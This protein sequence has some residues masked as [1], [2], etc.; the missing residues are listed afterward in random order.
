MWNAQTMKRS[1]GSSDPANRLSARRRQRISTPATIIEDKMKTNEQLQRDIMEELAWEPSI[2]EA[3]IGVSAHDG[4]V[5]LS[6][7]VKTF[8]EKYAAVK[9]A[10]RVRGVQGL[11]D[12][13][14]VRFASDIRH[15]DSDIATSALN[16]LRTNVFVPKDAIK[17]SVN[18]GW[19]SLEGI[20]DWNYQK[21]HAAKAVRYLPGVRGL[22]NQIDVKSKI[23][24]KDVQDQI[25]A[26]LKRS[27]E[28]EAEGITVRTQGDT[29]ILKGTVRSWAEKNAAERAAWSALGVKKVESHLVINEYAFA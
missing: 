15:D 28:L 29:V 8:A 19:L 20:V 18:N 5:T 25:R 7:H 21:E 3:A 14:E 23:R 17:V 11:A 13:L 9:A 6:G 2:D 1:V 26:A 4:V 27:S 12:D 10:K 22:T 16:A 24:A